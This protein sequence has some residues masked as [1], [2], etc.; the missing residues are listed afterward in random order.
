MRRRYF[1]EVEVNDFKPEK[2]T[3]IIETANREWLFPYS[4]KY[5]DTLFFQGE[6]YL[7]WG[8]SE[9]EFV[10]HITKAI[11]KQNGDFCKVFVRATLLDPLPFEEYELGIE[12]YVRFTEEMRRKK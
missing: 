11:W 6:G 10:H 4:A 8:E 9:E 12:D 2:M 5:G 3:D 1:M 7:R